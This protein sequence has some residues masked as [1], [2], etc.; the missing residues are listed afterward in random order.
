MSDMD[1]QDWEFAILY[2]RFVAAGGLDS[3]N[4]VSQDFELMRR[5]LLCVHGVLK[6]E[7]EYCA[8]PPL[9][10]LDPEFFR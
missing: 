2:Q 9:K 1:D 5:Q 3:P 4:S 7:C 8:D 10:G 6:R